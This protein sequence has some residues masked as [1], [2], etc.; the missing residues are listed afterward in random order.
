[1]LLVAGCC[2]ACGMA[3]DDDD[4]RKRY[5]YLTLSD[6]QFEHFV[7]AH[8]DL[9]GDRRLSRYEAE[10]VVEMDCSEQGIHSLNEIS[11]FKNLQRLN[12]SK[13]N[14]QQ[15][16]LE[17]NRSLSELRCAENGL[18]EL[19]LG[20]VRSLT[21]IDCS[22]NRLTRIDLGAAVNLHWL[23]AEGNRFTTIDLVPCS[24]ALQARLRR[25]SQ[26]KTIYARSSQ[27]VDYES[28]AE[29]YER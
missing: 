10:R 23:D 4:E 29:L 1:M 21:Q 11:D 5:E 13:N 15:L 17:R 27:E 20:T 7:L 6:E 26:L 28:P 14:L 18:V 9:N 2:T 12:C 3:E 24:N 25:N 16:D 8:Y 19:Q 22:D